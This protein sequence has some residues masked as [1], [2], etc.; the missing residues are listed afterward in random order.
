MA[1]YSCHNLFITDGRRAVIKNFAVSNRMVTKIYNK[2]S[3][4][5]ARSILKWVESHCFM[6]KVPKIIFTYTKVSFMMRVIS[7]S[8]FDKLHREIDRQ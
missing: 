4:K 8:S 7:I 6:K 3:K 5:H 2:T 1:R